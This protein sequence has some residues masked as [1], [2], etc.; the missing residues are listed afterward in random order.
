MLSIAA[1]DAAGYIELAL[2]GGVNNAEYEAAVRTID[3]LIA[4]HDR[5]NAVEVIHGMPILP[6]SL[7]W[8]DLNYS[9]SHLEK[10][11]RCAVV[12]DSGWIGPISRFLAALLPIEFR[13]FPLGEL[14]QARAWARGS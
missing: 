9:L 13:T 11:G 6:P 4:K 5:I 8:R 1:D 7:W 2:D 3:R 10:F 12:S 14:E